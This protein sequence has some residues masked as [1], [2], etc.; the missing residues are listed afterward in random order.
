MPT[1]KIV[2]VEIPSDDCGSQVNDYAAQVDN[3]NTKGNAA[4]GA[5]GFLVCVRVSGGGCGGGG[6]GGGGD[7]EGGGEGGSGGGDGGDGGGGDG[8]GEDGGEGGGIGGID[9]DV[10]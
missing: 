2:V 10:M 4:Y 7:G 5:L 9:R 1:Y 8:G 6:G 3:G